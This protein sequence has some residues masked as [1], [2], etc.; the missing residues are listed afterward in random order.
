MLAS[1]RPV[2]AG[3]EP[4]RGIAR[5]IKGAGLICT[6][7]NGRSM[8]KA[9]E[10]FLYDKDLYQSFASEARR[11]AENRWGREAIIAAAEREMMALSAAASKPSTVKNQGAAQ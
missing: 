4:G 1:G 6:P 3:V 9:I 5:E 11:R 2:V 8:A 10:K 7:E